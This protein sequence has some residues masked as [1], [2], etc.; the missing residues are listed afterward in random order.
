[1]YQLVAKT[2]NEGIE[3]VKANSRKFV[4]K[5]ADQYYDCVDIYAVEVTDFETG[6]LLYYK[7]KG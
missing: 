5:L 6:E 1:M 2:L 4:E 3:K 7:A